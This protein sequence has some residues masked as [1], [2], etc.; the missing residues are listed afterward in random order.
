MR[1]LTVLIAEA[2]VGAELCRR[3]IEIAD[4]LSNVIKF[5]V[6]FE[7]GETTLILVRVH[8][9]MVLTKVICL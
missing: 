6:I 1:Q 2:N 5:H 8:L 9:K 7:Q 3:S 4:N